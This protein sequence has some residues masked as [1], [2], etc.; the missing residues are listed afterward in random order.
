M[1]RAYRVLRNRIGGLLQEIGV[2]RPWDVDEFCQRVAHHRGTPLRLVPIELPPGAPDGVWLAGRDWDMIIYDAHT[3]AL[4]AEH[5]ICHELGHMLLEHQGVEL[6][7][8]TPDLDPAVLTRML[9]RSGYDDAREREAELAAALIWELAGRATP[10]R[11]RTRAAADAEIVDRLADLLAD[12][13]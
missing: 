6:A 12:D 8:L 1:T 5:I 10:R 3:S 13:R 9:A 11:P 4:R 2:P 7:D